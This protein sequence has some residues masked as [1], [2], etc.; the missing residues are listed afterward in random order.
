[1]GTKWGMQL[2]FIILPILMQRPQLL[3]TAE[4]ICNHGWYNQANCWKIHQWRIVGRKIRKRVWAPIMQRK[5]L[6]PLCC[7]I[8]LR[9]CS[10]YSTE[11]RAQ[12]AWLCYLRYQNK[13]MYKDRRRVVLLRFILGQNLEM[14]L[15]LRLQISMAAK[16]CL[17]QTHR[18]WHIQIP[19]NSLVK[20]L[21][22]HYSMVKEDQ[23]HKD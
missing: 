11:N 20:F 4:V 21:M 23:G 14:G 7:I 12:A 1:M 13:S 9:K 22:H 19:K 18:L 2:L 10:R 6:L 5:D 8:P 17:P 16:E 15:R 3:R